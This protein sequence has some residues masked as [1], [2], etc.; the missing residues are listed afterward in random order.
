MLESF[1][2]SNQSRNTP[3]KTETWLLHPLNG[4][5]K[6]RKEK[7][8]ETASRPLV[9]VVRQRMPLCTSSLRSP[10]FVDLPGVHDRQIR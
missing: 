10:P 8:K 2:L 6:K 5:K 3:S 9:S 4:E 7:K 1:T